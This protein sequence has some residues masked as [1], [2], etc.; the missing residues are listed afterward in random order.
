MDNKIYKNQSNNVL[1]TWIFLIL[2]SLLIG[3]VGFLL[4]SYFQNP[5]F[6]YLGTFVSV[7]MSI[8]SYWNSSNMVLKMANARPLGNGE[9]MELQR[10]V[11]KLSSQAGLPMP[12]IFIVE[13]PSPNA[14]ATGRNPE[15]GVI[16]FTTGIL[17]LLNKDE[18]AGVTAHELSH[19]ANRDT[20]I[21]TVVAV[22][23]NIIQSIAHFAFYFGGNQNNKESNV[24]SGIV[25]TLVI[26][27]LA[28]LSATLIQLAISRRREFLADGSGALLTGYPQGLA[29]ALEKIEKYPQGMQIV[30]PAISHL[31]ISNPEKDNADHHTPWYVK[32]FMTHPPTKD[33]VEALL[34]NK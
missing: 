24:V 16:A 20:L 6:F 15:N 7:G 26:A 25:A 31:F 33:R 27:I 18:L 23:A 21:M 14:F 28:P 12:K 5:I 30:N 32:L 22:M 2:F 11:E 10:M 17:S 34:G 9:N 4:A 1:K 3:L 19:I 29:T 8:W 13:D